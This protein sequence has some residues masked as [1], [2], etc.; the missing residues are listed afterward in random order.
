MHPAVLAEQERRIAGIAKDHPEAIVVVESALIFTTRHGGGG[1][2]WRNRFDQ[3]IVVTAPDEVKIDRFVERVAA[4]RSLREAD[5]AALQADAQQ[6]LAAQR[7]P[8]EA[9]AACLKLENSGD[10]AMLE[11]RTD[12]IFRRLQQ[13]HQP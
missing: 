4:G 9:T 6:R 10:L 5:R 1:E 8:A 12:E 13:Q 3:I 2:P 7:I 11:K